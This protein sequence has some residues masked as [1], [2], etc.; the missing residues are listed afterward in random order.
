MKMI[1]CPYCFS[2][3]PDDAVH[4]R[5]ERVSEG[6]NPFV[7]EDYDDFE[8]FEQNC[9]DKLS[10]AYQKAR[11]W[12]FFKESNGDE[13]YNHFWEQHGGTTTEEI[14]QQKASWRRRVLDPSN[15]EH[16]QYLK[17]QNDG[18]DYKKYLYMV[19]DFTTSITLTSGEIC[20]QRV[21]PE[22]HNP[23]P[24]QYGKHESRFIAV[25]G[26]TGAG[27]TV[28]LS[29]LVYGFD[30]Y[31]VKVGLAAL[32]TTDS[33][34][35]FL[36]KNPVNTKVPLPGSTPPGNFLQPLFYDL[37]KLDE[38][39]KRKVYTL[40]IYDVAG[41]NCDME[42]MHS[43]FNSFIV[44][45]HGVFL[46]IDPMQF[47]VI[48]GLSYDENA[49]EKGSPMKVLHTIHNTITEGRS[50]KCDIPL[51]VCISKSDMQ[52]VQ[53]VLDGE[54]TDMLMDDV[55]PVTDVSG[56]LMTQFNAKQY[57]PIA[58]KLHDFI[59]EN[60]MALENFI[61]VNYSCYNYFAFTSLGC[62]V[63]NNIPEGPI[64][65]K[66][67]EEPLLWLLNRF[68][69]VGENEKV[70]GYGD[71]CPICGCEGKRR[72]LFGDDRIVVTKKSL[73]GKPKEWE[74]YDFYCEGCN[75]YYNLD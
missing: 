35:K 73:F 69:F 51:A 15:P 58:V 20:T 53:D 36:R 56:A 16:Q 75:H 5:S 28:Y 7:P 67:I 39:G 6:V 59:K 43:W 9:K 26:V 65:P 23:L 47:K 52:D 21:C 50:G 34:L 17:P 45:M 42:K 24:N 19:E 57:N 14:S 72:R 32:Q 63:E 55:E 31:V 12:E 62:G 40:V 30:D 4:F 3:F 22:C 74:E 37:S 18:A 66:R 1:T 33:P 48:K 38:Y 44:H 54:L 13:K 49:E 61:N 29:Q 8:E 25:I 2:V 11:E 70:V 60:E 68:G 10:S 27:K 46:L 41:E 71:K 64:I